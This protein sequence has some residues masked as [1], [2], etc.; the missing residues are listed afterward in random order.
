MSNA[1]PYGDLD[2]PI[3][4][5]QPTNSSQ[6]S[7]MPERACKLLNLFIEQSKLEKFGDIYNIDLFAIGVLT[8]QNLMDASTSLKTAKTSLCWLLRLMN[9]LL[10]RTQQNI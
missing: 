2:V 3:I 4:M 8:F 5:E 7:A 9:L 10:R 6:E 1:Y